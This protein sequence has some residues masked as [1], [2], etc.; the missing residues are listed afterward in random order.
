MSTL[1][2]GNAFNSETISLGHAKK[3]WRRIDEQLPGGFRIKNVSS[4]VTSNNNKTPSAF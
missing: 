2:T 3:V 4:F 1:Q